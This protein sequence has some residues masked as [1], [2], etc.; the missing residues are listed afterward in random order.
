MST[1]T[2]R[3][4]RTGAWL[5]TALVTLVL[6]PVWASVAPM[7]AL[8]CVLSVLRP[9]TW[10]LGAYLVANDRP[11]AYV[12]RPRGDLIEVV[13]AAAVVLPHA[14]RDDLADDRHGRTDRERRG[15]RTRG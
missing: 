7:L 9:L 14:H 10:Q 3:Y 15:G 12:D 1:R 5:A 6:R 11:R 4:G 8:L 13:A 2:C